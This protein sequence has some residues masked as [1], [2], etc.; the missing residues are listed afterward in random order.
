MIIFF[1]LFHTTSNKS[2]HKREFVQKTTG[3]K[4]LSRVVHS[5]TE[6]IQLFFSSLNRFF[7][8]FSK[9]LFS[10][11]QNLLLNCIFNKIMNKSFSAKATYAA[12]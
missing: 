2:F 12:V 3:A 1:V 10:K 5:L 7:L 11:I 4:E 8:I 6:V 9:C